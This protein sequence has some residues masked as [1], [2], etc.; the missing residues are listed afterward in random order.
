MIAYL[1]NRYANNLNY[2]F[3]LKKIVETESEWNDIIDNIVD[4]REKT[5]FTCQILKEEHR[6]AELMDLI[7]QKN[8]IFLLEH[9]EKVLKKEVPERV[10]ALYK[11]Y[12][13]RMAD[14][15]SDRKKYRHLMPY[16]KKIASCKNGKA[17]ANQIAEEWHEKYK[18][19]TAMMD[20]L[21]KAGY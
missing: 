15:A 4:I 16:L 3:E 18:R 11:K 1:K 21:R 9:Y 2:Y 14:I 17:I 20:E 19:R 10:I 8:D 5:E 6:Y 12:L 13:I 7:E